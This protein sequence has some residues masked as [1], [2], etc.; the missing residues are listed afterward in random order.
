MKLRKQ[1]QEFRNPRVFYPDPKNVDLERVLINLFVLLRCDGSR[2]ASRGRPKT[3]AERVEHHLEQLIDGGGVSG[4]RENKGIASAWLESDVFDLVNRGTPREAVASLRPLHLDAHK[5]R[6]AKHCRDYNVS[7][8]IYAM[9]EYG[10]VQ[11]LGDLRRYLDRGRD[12]AT[13]RYDGS[14]GLDLETLTVLKLVEG[15][16]NLH[17]SGEK[18]ATAR[19]T[20]V[21]QSR[22]LCDDVERLL[23]YQDVV[24]R[25]VMIDYLKT[26]F[27]LHVGLYTLRLSR[28]L[29]GWIR[30]RRTH[31]ACRNCEVHGAK[32]APFET[33]PYQMGLVA[34]MQGDFRSRF[35]KIAQESAS[36]EYAHLVDLIRS[37]FT[38][39]QLLRYARDERAL[40]IVEDP[41]EVVRLLEDHPADFDADFR[42]RLKQLRQDNENADESL[43][44]DEVAI[45]ES[46]LPPFET[47]IE[48]VTHV[49]QKHHLSYLTQMLDKLFQKNGDASALVQGRSRANQRRWHL[50]GRLLEVFVQL[51]VLRWSDASGRKRFYSEPILVE[52][53][54]RWM[55]LRYGFIVGPSLTLVEQRPTTLDEHRAYRDNV[56]AMKDRLREIGFYDDLSDAYNAQTIRPRYP[57]DQRPPGGRS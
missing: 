10:G 6:V 55:E 37:L 29:A 2:P 47:F 54:L 26:I 22:V 20:C 27:G 46:G 38:M 44:P 42:A 13:N 56:R 11:V 9:L 16:P 7:D 23:A 32:D 19:P 15:L 25:A 48:L 43:A 35:A 30:D 1:D 49:R 21:G 36:R 28:Q 17:P 52:D 31:D 5:I 14:P 40:G 4:F 50:G 57:I 41:L 3:T 18:V 39:N 12:P 33:C 24:P 53:Y 45:L 51:A 8:A 34:D